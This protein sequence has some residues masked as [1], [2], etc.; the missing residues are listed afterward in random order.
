[1]ALRRGESPASENDGGQKRVASVNLA[2]LYR[3]TGREASESVDTDA[4]EG[5]GLVSEKAGASRK[6]SSATVRC[7]RLRMSGRWAAIELLPPSEDERREGL[8]AIRGVLSASA[9]ISG[10]TARRLERVTQLFGL[11]A[12][13]HAKAS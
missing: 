10:E 5:L 8:A 4:T 1:L 13:P 2:D 7:A 6:R 3:Q 11:A 12:E 9:A